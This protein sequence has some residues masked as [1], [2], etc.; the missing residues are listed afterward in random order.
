MARRAR[1][2]VVC[3]R[4]A[5]GAVSCALVLPAV[6][7]A[8]EFRDGAVLDEGA[9]EHRFDL[10]QRSWDAPSTDD[11]EPR[12]D[13]LRLAPSARFGL[14]PGYDVRVGLPVHEEDGRRDLHGL[15]LELGL[16][17]ADGEAGPDVTLAVHGRLLPADPPLGSG[18]EGVGVA[19]H[20][21]DRL[22]DEGAYL[23]GFIGLE[24]TDVAF[25][26]GPG[27]E[28][29]NRIHYAN[30]IEQP[31]GARWAVGAEVH[32]LIGLTGEE[33]QNQFGF[34]LRPVIRFDASESTTLRASVGRDRA[35]RGVVPESTV[36]LSLVHRPEPPT[37]RRE[38]EARL[39]E[40]EAGQER[41]G[42]Q[43]DGTTARQA[44]HA[45]RLA[46]HEERLDLLQRRAGS[47]D[48]E[49]VNRSGERVGADAVIEHLEELG[50]RV[51]RRMER[52][53]D[54]VQETT[55]VHYR[56]GHESAAVELGEALP[57]IQ[58]VIAAE[59]EL[60]RGAHVRVVVGSDFAAEED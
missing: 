6:A 4:L 20:L 58:E 5:I 12:D 30:R 34:D 25:R 55:F 8:L 42:R 11:A 26:D 56:E 18:T 15:E 48:V 50:H 16:P 31:I 22:G 54:E 53:G 45:G 21:S 46:V 52:P 29:V 27:Y 47:L 3:R 41:L 24:R 33:V 13:V 23:D 32:T 7:G 1:Q 36:Q 43:A 51:V 49:V 14:G 39:A 38:L 57:Q 17:L 2:P 44:R 59:P 37:P 35:D 19:V 28:A 10:E 40:L 60:G 9:T